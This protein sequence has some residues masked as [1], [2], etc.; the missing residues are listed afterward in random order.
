METINQI[1]VAQLVTLYV[2]FAS[3]VK[4]ID[5][6]WARFIKPKLEKEKKSFDIEVEISAIK[7]K[8]DKDYSLLSDHE[9]RISSVEEKV[10]FSEEDRKDLHNAIR[11]MIVGQQAITKS[12]LEDGNNKDGLQRAEEQLEDY[13][14]LKA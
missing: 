12:L 8:L 13:L 6:L 7:N 2:C 10:R 5:W 1:N 11:V 4:A 9:K 3:S 14:R